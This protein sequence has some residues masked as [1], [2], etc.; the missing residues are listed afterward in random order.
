MFYKLLHF[1]YTAKEKA[2]VAFWS[3]AV[4][5]YMAQNGLTLHDITTRSALWALVVGVV[6]HQLVYRITNSPKV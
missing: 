6:T 2:F 3:S 4:G 1:T 5:S